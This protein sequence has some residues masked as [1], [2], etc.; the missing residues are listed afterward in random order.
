MKSRPDLKDESLTE[1]V[2]RNL[3]PLVLQWAEGQGDTVDADEHTLR[4]LMTC[5][6]DCQEADGYKMAKTLEWVFAWTPDSKLVRIL[7]NAPHLKQDLYDERIEAWVLDNKVHPDL[8]VGTPVTVE[9]PSGD[10]HGEIQ[11][12]HHKQARY[13]VVG[14]GRILGVPYEQVHT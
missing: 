4:C 3:L 13:Q 8:D 7:D 1:E 12:V 9:T 14:G 5:L 11:A 10:F 6:K 2:A